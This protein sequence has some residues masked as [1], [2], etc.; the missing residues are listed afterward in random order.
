MPGWT[1]T[2]SKFGPAG[3]VRSQVL[4]AVAASVARRPSIQTKGGMSKEALMPK[5]SSNPQ[6]SGPPFTS[7]D[8][9]TL[10]ALA[11]ALE[12]LPPSSA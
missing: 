4:V 5:N 2:A 6:S 12:K 1:S 10:S 8:Q 9:S 7:P 3:P 11:G